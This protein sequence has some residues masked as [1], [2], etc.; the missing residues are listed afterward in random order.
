MDFIANEHS[1]RPKN[2]EDWLVMN[3]VKRG[4]T[5]LDSEIYTS[6]DLY[7]EIY[8]SEIYTIESIQWDLYS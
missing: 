2:V 7:S 4:Y 5:G 8:T 1:T 6:W 3:D